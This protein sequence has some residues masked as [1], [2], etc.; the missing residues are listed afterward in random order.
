VYKRQVSGSQEDL[1]YVSPKSGNIISKTIG[2]AY[3]DKLLLLPRFLNDPNQEI[4]DTD[5]ENAQK[6]VQLLF[7]K[8]I[9]NTKEINFN[10]II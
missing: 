1:Y 4:N 10:I 7:N 9:F 3:H 6:I 8:F 5:I 2:Q